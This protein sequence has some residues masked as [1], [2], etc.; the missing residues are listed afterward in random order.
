MQRLHSRAAAGLRDGAATVAVLAAV[1]LA[2][3][4]GLGVTNPTIVALTYLLVVLLVATL[5]TLWVAMASSVLALLALNY[6][7]MPPI[8]TLTIAD[9]ENWVAL[10]VLLVVSVTGQP[11][12][13]VGGGARAREALARRDELSRLFD[14]SRDILLTTESAE[15][16]SYA[17]AVDRAPL[18]SRLR[19][20]LPA[21]PRGV[22]AS[23]GGGSLPIAPARAD[24]DEPCAP[25]RRVIEFDARERTYG[26]HREVDRA[27]RVRA[28]GSC[29]FDWAAAPSACSRRPGGRSSRAR[30]TPWRA[31]W[32]SPSSA[33]S[34]SRSA[35]RPSSPGRAAS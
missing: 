12:L 30:S 29:R 26:G 19:R 9:P 33:P 21:G 15:A 16:H 24:L 11:A 2:L 18:R 22:G 20:D 31:S 23:R 28:S 1:T 14:L 5:S 13:L 34:S 32:P 25:R 17:G 8:G 3:S 35:R 4:G 10:F 7:F 27:R 6:F